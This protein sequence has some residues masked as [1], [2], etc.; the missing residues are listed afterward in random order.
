MGYQRSCLGFPTTDEYA[1]SDG[2]RN[3]FAHGSITYRSS[4]H[5]TTASC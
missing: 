1:I 5:T 4:T 2:R 3:L